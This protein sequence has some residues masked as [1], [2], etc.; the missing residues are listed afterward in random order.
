MSAGMGECKDCGSCAKCEKPVRKSLVE[1]GYSRIQR[2]GSSDE[3][4][5]RGNERAIYSLDDDK[6]V[7]EYQN[8]VGEIRKNGRRIL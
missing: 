3:V 8:G 6:V 1:R 2:V 7:L 5:G 4:W